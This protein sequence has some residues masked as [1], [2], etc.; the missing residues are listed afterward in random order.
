M[1]TAA[2]APNGGMNMN[3]GMGMADQMMT[4]PQM[5]HMQMMPMMH[6]H[7]MH[8]MHQQHL[9][10]MIAQQVQQAVTQQMQQMMMARQMPQ[11]NPMAMYGMPHQQMFQPP[12]FQQAM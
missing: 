4:S 9:Q 12:M 11:G 5:M 10:Q 8:M 3:M 6:P 7:M 2:F 1:S